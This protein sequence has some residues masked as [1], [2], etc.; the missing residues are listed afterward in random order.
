ML[1]EAENLTPADPRN[2]KQDIAFG[3][4]FHAGRRVHQADEYMAAITAE[5]L[6]EYL[7]RAGYVIF[8]KP[9]L[10]G[11]GQNRGPRREG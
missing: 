10:G 8:K 5:R 11:H 3:L 4:R 1:D 7:D 9:P 2:L 6:I